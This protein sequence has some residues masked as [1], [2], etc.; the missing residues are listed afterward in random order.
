MKINKRGPLVNP[1]CDYQKGVCTM[2]YETKVI[3]ALL[4]RNIGKAK[5]VKG[6]YNAVV[7]AA[8]VEGLELPPYE[9]ASKEDEDE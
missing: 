9:V 6:A 1:E 7:A 2:G 4:A 3:L 5:T 8:S